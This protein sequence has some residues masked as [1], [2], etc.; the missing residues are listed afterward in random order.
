[1]LPVLK[2]VSDIQPGEPHSK[3]V[4]FRVSIS[5]GVSGNSKQISLMRDLRSLKEY[6]RQLGRMPGRREQKHTF[7]IHT[8][9]P[10]LP[11]QEGTEKI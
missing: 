11:A 9:L 3:P 8:L 1:M 6:M 10:G 7:G 2:H 5:P 4:S